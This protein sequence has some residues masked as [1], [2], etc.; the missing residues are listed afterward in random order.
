MTASRI[1]T[2]SLLL[3]GAATALPPLS[4]DMALPAISS[5]GTALGGTSAMAAQTIGLF[6][7]GFVL[8][9]LFFGPISDRIGRRPVL[10]GGLTVFT[11]ASVLCA[12]ASSMEIL[13]IAR[14]VQGAAAGAA[15][16][17]PVAIVRD[18]Y[19]GR[20]GRTMQNALVAINNVAPLVAPLIGA[21]IL[22]IGNWREIYGALAIAGSVL[23]LA[24]LR[25]KEPH[26]RPHQSGQ[27]L[28]STY[29]RV[30]CSKR[31]MIAALILALN[32]A[33]M[34]AY[35]TASPLV[36]MEG[37][38]MSSQGF[39][40]LFAVTALGTLSGSWLNS[41]MIR[42]G[43]SEA[44]VIGI[45]LFISALCS[46]SLLVASASSAEVA[47]YAV[48]V[49][50]SNVCT[51]LVMPNATHA[52]LDDLGQMAG[53]G[54]ALLRALQM[55][56]GAAASFLVGHFYDGHTARSMAFVMTGCAI[57]ALVSYGL[58]HSRLSRQEKQHAQ[59]Y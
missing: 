22:T 48:L 28:V 4:I 6:I 8:G 38:G 5:L 51:G 21:A 44:K 39:S 58:G 49:V 14:F 46:F 23:I 50:L 18:A 55:A 41:R 26:P 37:M 43:W 53:S 11:L 7:L 9:P 42:A 52:A 30:L 24:A 56:G 35:I 25:L 29:A 19:H 2:S 10:L 54:A 17:M 40:L 12:L 27:R 16:V 31:F 32:F 1:T 13:L 45:S 15:A 20:E 36:F 33:G 59:G 47:I 57:L 3:L 34:F